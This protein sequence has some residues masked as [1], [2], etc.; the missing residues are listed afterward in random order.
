MN[1]KIIKRIIIFYLITVIIGTLSHF[2]FNTFNFDNFL[3]VI[4]PI[5]ESTFEHLKLFFYPF[6]T[7]SIIEGLIYKEKLDE[8]IS[9]R[10]FI[11]SFIML[12][13]ITYISIMTKIFGSNT[14][15]NVSSYYILMLITFILSYKINTNSKVFKY[16]GYLNIFL[17][18][19]LF[20][21]YTYKPLDT[22]IFI[23]PSK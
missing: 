6:I 14:I 16:G 21:I 1:K 5:N 18:L 4:F 7:I 12:F 11:I 15:I 22:N 17:W 19:V 23:D 3:K 10:G 20:S 8:F 13:E 9:K 2:A